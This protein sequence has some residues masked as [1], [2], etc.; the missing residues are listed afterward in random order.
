MS[1]TFHLYS[2]SYH[3]NLSTFPADSL[4]LFA[5]SSNCSLT[6]LTEYLPCSFQFTLTGRKDFTSLVCFPFSIP[7]TVPKTQNP[8]NFSMLMIA[9]KS[10]SF[11]SVCFFLHTFTSICMYLGTSSSDSSTFHHSSFWQTTNL[12]IVP[13]LQ[14][15]GKHSRHQIFFIPRSFHPIITT[16]FYTLC[17]VSLRSALLSPFAHLGLI[18]ALRFSL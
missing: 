12:S 13:R 11:P 8:V 7:L 16:V 14:T 4:L 3:L 6:C 15:N 18:Q 5:F 2:L 10:N 9:Q 17:D 1:T